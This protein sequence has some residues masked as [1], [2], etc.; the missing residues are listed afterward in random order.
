MILEVKKNVAGRCVKQ[1]VNANSEW[2]AEAYMETDY[3][4]LKKEHF[5]NEIK[6][7]VLFKEI[8]KSN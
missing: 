2:C 3:S 7:F 1:K 5:E 4:N 6:R 8:N